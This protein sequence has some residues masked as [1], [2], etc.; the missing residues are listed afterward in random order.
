MRIVFVA[1]FA[2]TPKATVSARMAPLAAALVAAGHEVVVVVPPYDNPA[3]G[4]KCWERDGVRYE[5]A[6]ASGAGALAQR[7]LATQLLRRT[8]ELAP[9]LVHAF[10]P[11]G[12]GALA[13]DALGGRLPGVLDLDDWEGRG[14]WASEGAYS[15]PIRLG[16]DAQERW[17]VRRAGARGAALTCASEV[18]CERARAFSGRA[19]PLLLPNGPAPALRDDVAR[20]EANRDA[21]RAGFG[22]AGRTVMVYAGTIPHRNDMDIALRAFEGRAAAHPDL[23]WEV[24]ASGEGLPSFAATVA[25]S[26]MAAR[27]HL[28]GFMPHAALVE[29][30]VAADLA[31][32]PYRDTPI[33]RAKC[34]GKVIDYMAAGLPMVLSDV[35]MNR[36][37]VTDGNSALLTPPGDAAAFETALE[38]LLGNPAYAKEVGH[39]AQAR[40]WA[41]FAWPERLPALLDLYARV[42]RR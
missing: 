41:H 11:V 21:L 34:S 30:L 14:G 33:N 3:D 23:H 16:L 10:K 28:H 1:P 8:R 17:T 15:L 32:Y 18:L 36:H 25:A 42:R 2:F 26:P 20:A 22:H 6:V 19:D 5:N 37:Y 38:R 24:I 31:V 39:A 7:S 35:G 9:D 4:G 27:I 13:F 12:P 40:L 29:R